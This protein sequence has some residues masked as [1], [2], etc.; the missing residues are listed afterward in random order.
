M[1]APKECSCHSQQEVALWAGVYWDSH[2]PAGPE[3]PRYSAQASKL[4]KTQLWT[5][6][7]GRGETASSQCVGNCARQQ[8]GAYRLDG[9]GSAAYYETR[10]HSVTSA[11]LTTEV[12]ELD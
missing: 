9:L 1:G 5:V 10:S 8:A 2:S 4:G 3:V 7:Y 12:C 6:A 11:Q